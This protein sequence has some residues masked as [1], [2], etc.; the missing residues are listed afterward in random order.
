MLSLYLNMNHPKYLVMN[1]VY[2]G[3]YIVPMKY[4]YE[5]YINFSGHISWLSVLNPIKNY[6]KIKNIYNI[7]D[8]N[9]Y[10]IIK[11]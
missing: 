5:P 9:L 2:N 1:P 10:S 11:R 6:S 7:D 4:E 3:F 8:Y